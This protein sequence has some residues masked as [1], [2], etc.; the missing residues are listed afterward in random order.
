MKRYT[1]LFYLF[2]FSVFAC[3]VT[4]AQVGADDDSSDRPGTPAE[5]AATP[6]H[7]ARVVE[8]SMHEFMEYVFQPTYRRLKGAMAEEPSDKKGWKA[9]KSD[10]L[11]LA[12]S[13]NL[14]F[15]RSPKESA[16]DW[17]RHSATSRDDGD[18][19]YQAAGKKDF[20][21]A[22]TAWKSMLNNCN[23]CHRQFEDGKHILSP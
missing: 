16:D 15:A 9:I 13:C 18:A 7:Q 14:L 11:I 17:A 23:A 22:S 8:G 21:A 3:V 12:E 20:S 5:A 1:I 10:S 4:V 19:L 6:K 2:V